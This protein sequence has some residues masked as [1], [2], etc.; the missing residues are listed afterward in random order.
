MKGMVFTQL[1]EMAD[2]MLGPDKVEAII[3]SSNLSTGG[4]YTAVGNYPH[5]E[6]VTLAAAFSE[7][8]GVPVPDLLHHFG[9]HMLKFFHQNYPAFFT[10]S[11]DA[12][13][14]LESVETYV[15]VEVRKLYPDA[16]LPRFVT[17]RMSPTLMHSNTNS[18]AKP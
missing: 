7:A 18:S 9:E 12:F 16:E 11:P 5:S 10:K 13:S 8:S 6:A 2:S 15:H 14:F 3:A 4:A 17:E 1:I